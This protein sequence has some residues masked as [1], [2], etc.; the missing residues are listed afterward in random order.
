MP[1]ANTPMGK[2]PRPVVYIAII[3]GIGGLIYAYVKS[4]NKAATANTAA[5][6][7]ASGYG[8]GAGSYG[9]GNYPS[10]GYGYG[11]YTYEPYGYGFGPYGLGSYP[12]GAG[13]GYGLYGAG[14]PV[15]VPTQ[16]STNAQW[17]QAAISALT[18]QGYNG[19]EVLGALGPYLQGR[20]VNQSQVGIIQAAIAVEGNPPTEGP[21]GNPPGI[22]TGGNGG[23]GGGTKSSNSVKVPNVKGQPAGEAHNVIT[24]AGL[25]PQAVPLSGK[26]DTPQWRVVSQSP[27]AGTLVASG[28]TVMYF[29]VVNPATV[30]G[31]GKAT[32]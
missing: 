7:A 20:P 10:T 28:S 30:V 13:F 5:N 17:S 9:Y 15:Q 29:D 11:A 1:D 16:A 22:N 3:G 27:A 19:Q 25:R 6:A 26:K 24:A 2:I 14:V 23:G 21:G 31:G 12:G 4:K 32:K 18:A 8:Y